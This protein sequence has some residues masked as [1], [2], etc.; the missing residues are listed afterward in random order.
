M[1][2]DIEYTDEFEQ[3]WNGLDPEEQ[4]SIDASVELL[5]RFGPALPRPY[6]DHVK[7]SQYQ[8]MKELI[9]QHKGDPYRTLFAFDPRRV[10]ILLIGGNKGGDNRWYKTFVP[11]ADRLFAEHLKELKKEADDG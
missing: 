7:S 6:A 9:T 1:A 5:I 8:N 4:E 11:I 10:A 2:W 3:W